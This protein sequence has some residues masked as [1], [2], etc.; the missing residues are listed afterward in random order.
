ME[1]R[2]TLQ[3]RGRNTRDRVHEASQRTSQAL[4]E[5]TNSRH[6]LK[7]RTF[8]LTPTPACINPSDSMSSDS[9]RVCLFLAFDKNQSGKS[10]LFSGKPPGGKWTFPSFSAGS[11]QIDGDRARGMDEYPSPEAEQESHIHA[12]PYYPQRRRGG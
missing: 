10:Q 1:Y 5:H 8:V 6:S 3:V 4:G 2:S 12:A 11:R 7:H 9:P